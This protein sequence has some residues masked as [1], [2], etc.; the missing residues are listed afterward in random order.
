MATVT[1]TKPQTS[2]ASSKWRRGLGAFLLGRRASLLV[3]C[4]LAAAVILFPYWSG[5]AHWM[6]EIPLILCLALVVSGVNLSFG[7]AGELQL[8]QVFMFAVGAYVPM[9]LA[10]RGVTTDVVLLM[11]VGGALAVLV[12]VLVAVPALRIGGWSLAMA[13]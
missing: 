3:S 11:L 8:G 5:G 10:T 6:S 12:G 1:D 13:S 9:I 2:G 7:L 4:I